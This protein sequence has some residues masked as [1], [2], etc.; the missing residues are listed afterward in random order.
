[1]DLFGEDSARP[2]FE[3]PS[4]EG[5]SV[6]RIDG[7]EGFRILVPHGELIY[8][9]QFFDQKIS[10]RTVE[11]F[12]ENDTVDWK[13]TT[14]KDIPADKFANIRFKNI[15]W[16]QDVIR[17]YGKTTPLPRLT[18]WYGDSGKAYTY[19]GITSIPNEWNKGLLYLKWEIEKFAGVEFN[20]VLLNWYRDG[21][22]QLAWHA[23]D[24]KE[25]G[26]NPIIASANFGEPRDFIVRKNDDP[27]SKI[28]FP[29]NHGTLLLMRGD[30]QHYWQHSV[31]KRSKVSK[32]RFNLTF[33]RIGR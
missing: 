2:P 27:S 24:E 8:I 22:D 31:P 15:N 9:G 3:V 16:K 7:Y 5:Y 25:L 11:Y 6:E 20:S 19:S 17:M 21:T 18:S 32:S 26:L 13:T 23:D 33:R 30:L 28:V 12:Q 29:L 14:W 1:M 4:G 10:D